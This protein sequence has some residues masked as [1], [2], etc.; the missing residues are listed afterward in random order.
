[1]WP[2]VGWSVAGA[3]AV[4]AAVG[5]VEALAGQSK[6]DAASTDAD[7]ANA[8]ANP[9][10]YMNAAAKLSDGSSQRT[11]GRVLMIAGGAAAVA[12]LVVALTTGH[13]SDATATR[14]ARWQP[15]IDLEPGR[16]AFARLSV[17]GSW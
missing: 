16:L 13:A 3:G 5:I 1:M 12:G 15:S 2:I 11:T 10:L 4:I 6:I 14:V 8:M 9:T 7:R 17:A